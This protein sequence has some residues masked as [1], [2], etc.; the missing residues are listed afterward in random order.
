MLKP[1]ALSIRMG[2]HREKSRL[3]HGKVYHLYSTF[4]MDIKSMLDSIL[5]FGCV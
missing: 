3:L 4:A 5:G 1:H 2:A